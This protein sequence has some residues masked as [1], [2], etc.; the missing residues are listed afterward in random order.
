[1]KS[2][3]AGLILASSMAWMIAPVPATA[4]QGDA[5][6][7][8]EFRIKS[9]MP[10]LAFDRLEKS[11]IDVPGGQLTVGFAPGQFQVGKAKLLDWIERS[12]KAIS[13]YYGHF[14]VKAARILIVPDDGDKTSGGQTFSNAGA[15]IR[16]LA[17]SAITEDALKEDWQLPHEMVHLALPETGE[18]PWFSEGLAVYVESIARGQ[19][20][21][22]TEEKIWSEFTKMMP[23]G[24]PKKGDMGLGKAEGQER[25]YWGGATFWLIADLEIR[26]RTQNK[27]S[28]QD[29]LVGIQEAGG[30]Y[31]K[32]WPME[33]LLAVADAA[34][35]ERVLTELYGQWNSKPVSPDLKALWK[36]LGIEQN[37]ETV[38]FND[39]ASLAAT[40]RMLIESPK[41]RASRLKIEERKA[42]GGKLLETESCNAKKADYADWLVLREREYEEEAQS[43]KAHGVTLPPFAAVK[44]MLQTREEFDHRRSYEGFTCERISYASDGLKVTGYIWR[45]ANVE[46]KRLPLIIF[47]RGGGQE[48]SKLAP[49]DRDGFF[50]FVDSGFVVIGSQ[51]RGNDGGEGHD[52][53]GGAEV[54]DILNLIPLARELGYLDMDNV[55]MMGDSRGAMM[56]FLAMQKGMK[57]KAAAVVGSET[58]LSSNLKRRPELR[59]GYAKNIP[60]FSAE[61]EEI[62]HRRSAI[63]WP[64]AISAPLLMMHGAQDWRV[65]PSQD[66]AFGQKLEQLKKPYELLLIDQDVHL[67]TLNWRERDRR[68]IGWFKKHMGNPERP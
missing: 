13:V 2:K 40:R 50:D 51:Y 29:A 25:V 64:E 43:A 44:P 11:S 6:D 34:T 22:L 36:K 65:P 68:T 3:F 54:R 52:E 49:W 26:K 38:R 10:Y 27:R 21:D 14:P 31:E 24:L 32:V 59:E 20:G 41:Q 12:A 56:T 8:I 30:N 47:N 53:E 23:T 39:S 61:P 1:M 66:L 28:L 9:A 37:G 46:G 16:L 62:L 60:G 57:L 63:N 15:A 48:I 55:F 67:L 45:P 35:G 42:Q 5:K 19:A 4:Q 18:S 7:N 33:R 58:D 17:G